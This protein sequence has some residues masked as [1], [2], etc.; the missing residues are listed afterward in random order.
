MKIRLSLIVVSIFLLTCTTAFAQTS[1]EIDSHIA[2]A[3]QNFRDTFVNLSLPAPHPAALLAVVHRGVPLR[4]PQ[5]RLHPIEQVGMFTV[6]T[7]CA[8]ASK[9]R[10]GAK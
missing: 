3:A 9:L 6:M 5:F 2:A 8:Q 4:R 1:S 10:L 7:E